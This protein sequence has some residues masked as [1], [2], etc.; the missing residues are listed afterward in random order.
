MYWIKVKCSNDVM[1][2]DVLAFNEVESL[3]KKAATLTTPLGVAREDASQYNDTAEFV[4]KM[5]MEGQI[6][7]KASR[8]IPNQGG[9]MN[10]ENGAVYVDNNADH[11]GII[12]PNN[13][14]AA[15]RVA[16]DLIEVVIR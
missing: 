15:A 1:Q 10:V 14:E 7:A 11:D 16:G 12:C 2:G 4:V 6:Q 13:L 3:W 5:Q 9:E 8:D